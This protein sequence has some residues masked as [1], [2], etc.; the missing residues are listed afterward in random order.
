M[1]FPRRKPRNGYRWQLCPTCNGTGEVIGRWGSELGGKRIRCHSCFRAGWVEVPTRRAPKKSVDGAI[2][3]TDEGNPSTE[4]MWDWLKKPIDEEEL[5]G[6]PQDLSKDEASQPANKLSEV[7]PKGGKRDQEKRQRRMRRPIWSDLPSQRPSSQTSDL[8]ERDIHGANCDCKWCISLRKGYARAG[9]QTRL[10]FPRPPWE[11]PRK[12]WQWRGATGVVAILLLTVGSLFYLQGAFDRFLDERDNNSLAFYEPSHSPTQSFPAETAWSTP[13]AV[14]TPTPTERP[15]SDNTAA[16]DRGLTS[17]PAVITPPTPLPAPT[18]MPAHTPTPELSPSPTLPPASRATPFP[19]P[20]A[21]PASTPTPVVAPTP[22]PSPTPAPEPTP[23]LT[24][25]VPHLRHFDEKQYMLE[26][27]NAERTKAGLNPVELGDNPAAQLHAEDMLENCFSAH[28]GTDGL[29]PYMRYSLTGGYQSNSENVLGLDYCIRASDNNRP[30]QS[31]GQEI[32]DAIEEWMTSPGH[33][34]NILRSWHRKV[35][36]GIAWDEYNFKAIQHFEGNYVELDR[37]PIVV[38]GIHSMTGIAKNGVAFEDDQDLSVQIFYDPQ[39]RRLTRGQLSRTY[40]YSYGKQIAS[41]RPPLSGGWY[42]DEDHFVTFPTVPCRDP[43]EIPSDAPAPRSAN[44]ALQ[45]WLEALGSY[46]ESMELGS[47]VTVPWI[48]ATKWT[49]SGKAFSVA[50]DI[51]HILEKYG[52]GVYTVV[53]WAPLDGEDI[54]VSVYSLF[55]EG[56]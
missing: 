9:A 56:I 38:D 32:R 41:L 21:I 52:D 7:P 26:L 48:T 25:I 14:H 55:L 33:R 19:T 36:L 20:L 28:W 6:S 2:E 3:P 47:P 50:A 16:S 8:S 12:S 17:V 40:C 18:E 5:S 54:I 43:F 45:F 29:K 44:E 4:T 35:N 34:Q 27:I 24:P 15:L 31:I 1:P 10:R 37:L 23:E 51:E 42:Y 30:I 22:T 13:T 53:V 11:P 46:A 49:A 39:P